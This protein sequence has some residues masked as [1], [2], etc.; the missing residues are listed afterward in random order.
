M[1]ASSVK[2]IGTLETESEAESEEKIPT[3][4]QGNASI[5]DDK[6]AEPKTVETTLSSKELKGVLQGAF[7]S[8][9]LFKFAVAIVFVFNFLYTLFNSFRQ[10]DNSD[11]VGIS[12]HC[13]SGHKTF[14]IIIILTSTVVWFLVLVVVKFYTW[15]VRPRMYSLDLEN[16]IAD[17]VKNQS[18]F[19]K[20]LGDLLSAKYDDKHH[21]K[22]LVS[23]ILKLKSVLREQGQV[24]DPVFT[25]VQ[26]QLMAKKT[27][28]LTRAHGHCTARKA[29][30]FTGNAK[31]AVPDYLKESFPNNY[32]QYSEKHKTTG[33]LQDNEENTKKSIF[34]SARDNISMD[35]RHFYALDCHQKAIVSLKI[36]LIVTQAL[37]QLLI[38]PLLELQWLDQ[39]AWVCVADG[40]NR[41]YCSS[42][43]DADHLALDQVVVVY[44]FYASIVCATLLSLVICW[45]PQYVNEDDQDNKQNE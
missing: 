1:S 18:Y 27:P 44:M 19:I 36:F 2:E 16:K 4:S 37:V 20:E 12:C 9:A 17:T 25:G 33:L 38:I 30:R 21:R 29:V 11:N 35:Y 24:A 34:R 45:L 41:N 40:I 23:K 43:G 15:F 3:L 6:S 7:I 32:V 5:N 26:G 28:G 8:T 42:D 10:D 13:N 39:Y 14:Y 22:K 31:F